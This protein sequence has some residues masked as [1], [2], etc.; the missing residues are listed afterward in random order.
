[1]P[2]PTHP[3]LERRLEFFFLAKHSWGLGVCP[4]VGRCRT[5]STSGWVCHTTTTTW[6]CKAD[7]GLIVPNLTGILVRSAWR[8]CC[9]CTHHGQK[10]HAY[11]YLNSHGRAKDMLRNSS[12]FF[13]LPIHCFCVGTPLRQARLTVPLSAHSCRLGSLFA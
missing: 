1:M 9:T 6:D 8:Q 5:C 13:L 11:T 7:D 3:G 4:P 10:N 2:P 12:F